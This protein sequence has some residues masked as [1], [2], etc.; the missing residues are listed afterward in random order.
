MH[1]C[2]V[3]QAGHFMM[4]LQIL[5]CLEI[6]HNAI[7]LVPGGLL[8]AVAL[9]AGRDMLLFGVLASI[10]HVHVRESPAV[11]VIF[12]GWAST[13][14]I[15]YAFY[16]TNVQ[17]MCPYLLKWARYTVPLFVFPVVSY[18]EVYVEYLSLP[19]IRELGS[20]FW[21]TTVPMP[22]AWNFAADGASVLMGCMALHA[23][24]TPVLFSYLLGQRAKQFSSGSAKGKDAKVVTE[25]DKKRK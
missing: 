17:G 1:M 9:H 2:S 7:G 14:T 25:A 20:A 8:G 10:E 23:L 11:V 24:A 12:L 3:Y 19:I 4:I 18:V 21:L 15:R 6:I 5:S 22:N 13:E 16:A